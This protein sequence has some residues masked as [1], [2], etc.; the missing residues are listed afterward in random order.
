MLIRI[1][2][3]PRD[4]FRLVSSMITS[5]SPDEMEVDRREVESRDEYN[6]KVVEE[7]KCF[8]RWG[9]V[10]SPPSSTLAHLL[11][12][13][14]NVS[15]IFF[16]VSLVGQSSIRKAMRTRT[17]PDLVSKLHILSMP[18]WEQLLSI[19]GNRSEA[20]LW[21]RYELFHTSEMIREVWSFLT[22]FTTFLLYLPYPNAF[23]L[24]LC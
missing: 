17:D 6:P 5:K 16:C 7:P 23:Y 1:E 10:L 19:L 12:A 20:Q 22:R 13:N 9:K 3:D 11:R 4:K 18:G 21:R 8:R 2:M 15:V 24:D 14:G